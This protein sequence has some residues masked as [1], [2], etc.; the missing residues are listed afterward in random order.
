MQADQSTDTWAWASFPATWKHPL[1]SRTTGTL[2][3]AAFLQLPY[4]R[5][6]VRACLLACPL[7]VIEQLRVGEKAWDNIGINR[8]FKAVDA[9]QR[10]VAP[11]LKRAQQFGAHS[12]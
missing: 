1:A 2:R 5:A 6:S 10:K 11:A 7:Q 8:A 3:C 4:S 12:V 9:V